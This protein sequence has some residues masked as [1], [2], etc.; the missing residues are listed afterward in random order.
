MR[1]KAVIFDLDGTLINTLPDIADS[2]NRV[3][4]HFGLP[5]FPVD[6]YKY[7]TGNGAVTL[8]ERVIGTHKELAEQVLNEYLAEYAVHS[9][10]RSY[11]YPGIIDLFRYLVDHDIAICVLTNKDQSDAENVLSH[12]FPGIP[13]SAVQGRNPDFPLKPDPAGA[14]R[15][16]GKL[17]L[18]PEDFLY[19]GDTSMDMSCGNAA[20]METVGVLWGFRTKEELSAYG[21]SALVS[22]P[23]EIIALLQ[24]LD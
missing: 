17:S 10:D 16:A 2:M 23:D 8:T 14:L 18:T 3:L 20:H 5:V 12:Y 9:R 1:K 22:S 4:E 13:F 24:D 6:A 11:V 19:V 15:I 7:K 21:A